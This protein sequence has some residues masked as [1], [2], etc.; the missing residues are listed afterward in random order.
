MGY[1]KGFGFRNPNEKKGNEHGEVEVGKNIIRMH[2]VRKK[3]C[4]IK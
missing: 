3:S 1:I 4:L 2:Y